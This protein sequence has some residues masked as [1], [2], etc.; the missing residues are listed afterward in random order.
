MLQ[1]LFKKTAS[2]STKT[3]LIRV[4]NDFRINSDQKR[5]S[6]LA[7]LNIT[8]AFDT[9]D[10]DILTQMLHNSVGLDGPT[11]LGFHPN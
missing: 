9:V 10:R 11:L 5:F 1:I 6:V 3:A 4:S 8:T 2:I 7:W